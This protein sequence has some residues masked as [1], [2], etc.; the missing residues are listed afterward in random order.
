MTKLF[1]YIFITVFVFCTGYQSYGQVIYSPAPRRYARPPVYEDRV[2]VG[3]NRQNQNPELRVLKIKENFLRRQLDL[4]P[5]QAAKFFPLYHEYQM[6]LFN[7]LKLKRQN[8]TNAQANGTDQID[9]DMYYDGQIIK[10]K[11]RFKDAFLRILPPEKVSE[12]YKS[13]REFNDEL[14]RSLSERNG[15]RQQQP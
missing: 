1:K 12:L 14:V 13:E 2:V 11:Q 4:P 10:I 15:P 5:E 7:M 8:N 9:R 3:N 6:E